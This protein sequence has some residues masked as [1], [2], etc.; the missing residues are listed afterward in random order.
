M[1]FRWD[2]TSLIVHTPAKLNLFL[3][4]LNKRPDGFHDLETVMTMIGL[5]DTLRFSPV[6]PS[7]NSQCE[8][9][10]CLNKT[11]SACSDD[12][13]SGHD[14]LIVKAAKLL[15]EHAGYPGGAKIELW[16]RI[17]SQAGLGGGSSDAA[18][19]LVGLNHLWKLELSQEE[20][21][22][23]AARLGSDVP[24]FLS[25]LPIAVC[26]GRGEIVEPS[27]APAG[28]WFVIVKPESGL[29]TPAVFREWKPGDEKQSSGDLVRDLR[30]G[31]STGRL[32]NALQKPAASQNADISRLQDVFSSEPVFGHMM[33]GSGTAYFGLCRH[34]RHA[35][36][37]A[38]RLS[39][40]RIGRVT[41]AR[42][43]F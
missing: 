16:K 33:S 39:S 11:E 34:R 28:Q 32:Y 29:S 37:V 17:P 13:S 6:P 42:S 2:Q 10:L 41:V 43:Q 38:A 5:Y 36:W 26:R 12:I 1:L 15:K 27:D 3:E 8:I 22:E 20:L 24:F 21:S 14:N 4:V 18:A 25:H 30:Q 9:Q 31:K 23:L 7:E 35:N 40:R 19:T